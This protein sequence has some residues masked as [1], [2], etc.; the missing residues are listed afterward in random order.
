VVEVEGVR[1]FR[2]KRGRKAEFGG[3]AAANACDEHAAADIS[4]KFTTGGWGVHE[5]SRGLD[6]FRP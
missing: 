6:V 5:S 3:N 2:S 4:E 1:R